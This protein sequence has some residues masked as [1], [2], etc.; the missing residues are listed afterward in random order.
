MTSGLLVLLFR[1]DGYGCRRLTMIEHGASCRSE[2][3]KKF[4]PSSKLQRSQDWVTDRR[5]CFG[6]TDGSMAKMS[7][8]SPHISTREYLNEYEASK[9]SVMG[10]KAEPGCAAYP[11][12][13]QCKS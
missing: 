11:E 1:R 8:P 7:P 9:P 5:H 4:R 6:R 10:F 13:S 12:G 2:H 3:P